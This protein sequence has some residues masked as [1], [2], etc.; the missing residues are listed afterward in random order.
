M[1]QSNANVTLIHTCVGSDI[2][3]KKL[4]LADD[5]SSML[6]SNIENGPE[7]QKAKRFHNI[8]AHSRQD[9]LVVRLDDIVNVPVALLKVDT[10]GYEYNVLLESNSILQKYRPV[11]VFEH[12][13]KF[14]KNGDPLTFFKHNYNCER[15]GQ[16]EVCVPI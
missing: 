5:S 16:D 14:K 10:Q 8:K 12:D 9:V 6:K 4:N 15:M 3:L 11:V 1:F 13:H 2:S 7:Y